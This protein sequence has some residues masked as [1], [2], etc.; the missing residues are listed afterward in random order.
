MT[1]RP[2]VTT[3][4]FECLVL[5][6]VSACSAGDH[7]GPSTSG[8]TPG[9]WWTPPSPGSL[10]PNNV[11]PGTGGTAR[12]SLA[13]STTFFV[14][15]QGSD[16]T[17]DGSRAKPWATPSHAY[18]VLQ[19]R[20]D[21]RGSTATIKMFPGT[22]RDSV[23]ASAPLVGQGLGPGSVVFEGDIIDPDGVVVQP[24]SGYAFSAASGAAFT[25]RG[26]RL[27]GSQSPADELV[28]GKDSSITIEYVDF[29]PS[30]GNHMSA[31][32]NGYIGVNSSYWISGSARS[33]LSVTNQGTAYYNTNGAPG[34]VVVWIQGTPSFSTAFFDIN[35]FSSVNAQAI[36][37]NGSAH[38][39]QFAVSQTST[40]DIGGT[41]T[42]ALPGDAP[43][44]TDSGG[45]VLSD[46]A[47]LD[48]YVDHYPPDLSVWATP[49]VVAPGGS[50]SLQWVAHH[51]EPTATCWV[52][53]P[54]G[55]GGGYFTH[56][57]DTETTISTGFMAFG[58]KDTGP[59]AASTKFTLYCTG[60]DGSAQSMP[61]TVSVSEAV[62]PPPP[63]RIALGAAATFHVDPMGSDASGEGSTAHPWA[64][65]SHAYAMLQSRYDLAGHP[66][67]IAMAH[68]VYHD[69]VQA[70]GPLAGQGDMTSVV[71]E[72]DVASPDAVV[73]KPSAGYSFAAA[74]AAAYSIRGVRVDNSG[75]AA[76]EIAIGQHSSL[77][78][79]AVDFG[80]TSASYFNN[81]S[82]AFGGN[83]YVDGNYRI[84]GG[85]Q[86]HMDIA[87]QSYVYYRHNPDGTPI[88]VQ[89][90]G[91][92]TFSSAF[93]YVASNCIVNA[94]GVVWNGV[95]HGKQFVVEGNAQILAGAGGGYLPGD[96]TGVTRTGGQVQ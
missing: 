69:S 55:Y 34:L 41:S 28:V 38:G 12:Q 19:Q 30:H 67:T 35:G 93:L 63:A 85:G 92:P 59:L 73:M 71:F 53:G 21:L 51:V 27:D 86:A 26:I 83:V 84:S 61:F 49:S 9:P 57:P 5:V 17:G 56:A 3:S 60:V 14:H 90:D 23:Q 8:P 2:A 46:P 77:S 74:F 10:L 65:P 72:G 70:Y 39:K 80:P 76:D 88:S 87:N 82:A 52:S 64:T 1:A 96:V 15:P 79:A 91:A 20:Y 22:Y 18:G 89:I 75:S 6:F 58:T 25:V 44:A 36:G 32:A 4:L 95:A 62:P 68:G 54:G 81:L 42:A 16:I 7:S 31:S 11:P 48:G 66:V 78:I 24:P 37:W 50:V 33:H 45:Q 40:L 94:K 29:G 43:G 13:A 47:E